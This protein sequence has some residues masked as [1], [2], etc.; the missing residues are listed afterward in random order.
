MA[1]STID[2]RLVQEG[3]PTRG[4]PSAPAQARGA[5]GVS[6]LAPTA[7]ATPASDTGTHAPHASSPTGGKSLGGFIGGMILHEGFTA[8]TS[9]MANFNP[10]K[11][12]EAN[13][14]GSIGGGALRRQP[15]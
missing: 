13:F 7:T 5:A 6:T 11:R 2:I 14:L 8:L 15:H 10:T 3:A 9:S 12:R 4:A 1:D